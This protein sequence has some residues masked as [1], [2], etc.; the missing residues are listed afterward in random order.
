M[1]IFEDKMFSE[2]DNSDNTHC[3]GIIILIYRHFE[4][5]Y[6]LAGGLSPEPQ[7]E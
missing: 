4:I 5:F 6:Y 1:G 3:N 2:N 7:T